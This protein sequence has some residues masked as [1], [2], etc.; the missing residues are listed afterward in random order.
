MSG[1]SSPASSVHSNQ[2]FKSNNHSQPQL[3]LITL[4]QSSSSSSSDYKDQQLQLHLQTIGILV[5]EKAELHSKLQQT[6]KKCDKKQEECDELTGRLKASRQKIT[7]LEKLVQHLN[8]NLANHSPNDTFSNNNNHH[9]EDENHLHSNHL[10]IIDEL[11]LR[12]NETNDKL[13]QKQIELNDMFQLN[14]DLTTQ[15]ELINMKFAQFSSTTTTSLDQTTSLE[16]LKKELEESEERAASLQAKNQTLQAT[17]HD[18]EF[19]LKQQHEKLKQDYQQYVD[20]F[21]SQIESLVDQ[22]NR[23][24]DE[25]EASFSKIDSL[26]I[27]LKEARKHGESLEL[28]LREANEKYE[29]QAVSKLFIELFLTF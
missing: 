14:T 20:Q 18:Y 29:L 9:E 2:A 10:L 12:L 1:R 5:A 23:L 22:I 25:R 15:L 28:Q 21:K 4:Q 13:V 7:E 11:R 26:E 27:K 19:K 3:P 17:V 6:S 8:Q 16:S 24:T